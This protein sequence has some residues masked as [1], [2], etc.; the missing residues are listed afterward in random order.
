MKKLISLLLV[1]SICVSVLAACGG[2][3][4]ATTEQTTTAATTAATTEATIPAPTTSAEAKAALDGKRILFVGNSYTY[5]GRVVIPQGSTLSQ[6][7]RNNNQGMF[8]YMCQEK[9]IDVEVTNWTFGG[10]DLTDSLGHSCTMSEE[11]CA[12]VDHLSYLTDPYF[13]YVCLQPYFENEY[14]GDMVSHLKPF[15]D[16]FRDANPN[17]KFLLLIPHMTYVRNFVWREDYKAVA[18]EG[19]I[20]CDWGTMLDDILNKRVEVPGGTQQYF[21][22]TFVISQ[23]EKDGHHQNLLVGYLTAQMV[24]CA[25]TGESAVG[26]P[27]GFADDSSIHPEFD[28][29]AYQKRYYTYEP[30]TN[31]VDVYRSESDMRG[32]QQLI[33]QYIIK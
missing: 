13:D 12:G 14:T 4:P 7:E 30:F 8:Y 28:M 33:D 19:V 20:I 15:M 16:F 31:F 26:Q 1:L 3:A 22:G 18:D 2:E 29:E 27:Y 11:S 5:Y 25:I 17:V 9:G 24:Y 10:H 21:F 6:A 23:N 32:L